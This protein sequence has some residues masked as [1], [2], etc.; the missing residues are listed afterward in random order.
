[1][2]TFFFKLDYPKTN[3]LAHTTKWKV[4][5]IT[6]FVN[7]IEISTAHSIPRRITIDF[8][9]CIASTKLDGGILRKSTYGKVARHLF[10]KRK[11]KR[12]PFWWYAIHIITKIT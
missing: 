10:Y 7:I 1:M 8:R 9:F 3:C 4:F 5:R 11:P 12:H 2:T 6:L